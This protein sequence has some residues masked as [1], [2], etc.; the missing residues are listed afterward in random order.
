MM[1]FRSGMANGV[2]KSADRLVQLCA[3]VYTHNSN[4]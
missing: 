1:L 2:A 4:K 3:P